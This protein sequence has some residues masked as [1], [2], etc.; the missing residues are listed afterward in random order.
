MPGSR[1]RRGKQI[2]Y[3]TWND[4]QL[5][6][7]CKMNLQTKN[8]ETI[9]LNKG[10]YRTPAFSPDGKK[11]IFRKQVGDNELGLV[12]SSKPGI[13]IMDA[14]GGNLKFL[15]DLGEYPRFSPDGKRIY[16]STGGN[17]FG[18]LDKSYRS[19]DLSGKD[20][21]ILA[22]GKYTNQWTPSPDGKWLAFSDLHKAYVCAMP[23]PGQTLD[24]SGGMGSVPVTLVSR[25]PSQRP[26]H[27]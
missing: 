15:S 25:D 27:R 21:R 18:A 19:Y 3:V 8:V 4:E 6:A 2:V 1:G 10:I 12:F 16:V 17:L 14:D 9:K 7:V 20:E 24:V 5:G 13:Y 26:G 22:K 23:M 11:I